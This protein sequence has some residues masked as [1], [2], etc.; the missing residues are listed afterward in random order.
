[1]HI[2]RQ[3]SFRFTNYIALGVTFNRIWWWDYSSRT[4][5]S[6][7]YLIIAITN[8]CSVL[9]TTLNCILKFWGVCYATSL[10]LFPG[11]ICPGRVLSFRSYIDAFVFL[12]VWV[13]WHIN[14]CRLFIAKSIFIKKQFYFKQFNFA[15]VHNLIVNNISI[16]SYSV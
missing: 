13:L 6:M 10:P 15:Y 2:C 9:G 3:T 12:F 16:S 4:I 8:Y 5:R 14:L 11:Q 1:M 7:S